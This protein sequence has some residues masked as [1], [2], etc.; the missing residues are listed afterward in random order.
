MKVLELVK[1]YLS[2]RKRVAGAKNAG[3]H[4]GTFNL[5]AYIARSALLTPIPQ[6]FEN[7]LTVI[8]IGC[9]LQNF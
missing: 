7:K 4:V 5:S 1:N 8:D 6:P 3:E 2:A 9:A